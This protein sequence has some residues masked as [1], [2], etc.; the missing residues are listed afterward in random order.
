MIRKTKF[1]STKYLN[2]K[3]PDPS[4]EANTDGRNLSYN[5]KNGGQQT[6]RSG[7]SE[8]LDK[9]TSQA[10]VNNGG[11][12]QNSQA[13]TTNPDQTGEVI[14]IP[15]TRGQITPEMVGR[16]NK[17]DSLTDFKV[18]ISLSMSG[19]IQQETDINLARRAYD[20][21]LSLEYPSSA[22]IVRIFTSST[23]TDTK[24]ERNTWMEKAYPRLKRYCLARGYEFQ[25]VDM[26]WGVRD[27]ATDDHRGTELCLRELELCQTLST[28]PNFI[29]LLSHKYGYTSLPREIDAE[30]F[31]KIFTS[32]EKDDQNLLNKW[33]KRDDNS[34][35]PVFVLQTISKLLPDFMS[36]DQEKKKAAK[37]IWWNE[38]EALQKTLTDVSKKVL[39]EK[40]AMKYIL[41]ITHLEVLKGVLESKDPS[42]ECLWYKRTIKD[43]EHLEPS[44][45][46]SRYIECLGPV[47]KWQNSR[48]LLGKL[49][50]KM[51]DILPTSNV[52]E[53]NVSWAE[54]GIDPTRADHADYLNHINDD[55]EQKMMKMI[56]SA[57]NKRENAG[58]QEP[59][60]Q[61]C[62]QHLEFCQ[63]KSQA[64]GRSDDLQ[65]IK[66][67]LE[68]TS[69]LPFVVHATSG[70]GKTTV[71]AMAASKTKAWLSANVSVVVRFV[72]TTSESTDLFP[73][74]QNLTQ[75]IKKAKGEYAF[76]VEGDLKRLVSEFHASLQGVRPDRPLVIY[77]DALD[78]F[79]AGN[80]ARELFWL[81]KILPDSVKLVVSTL[82][83]AKYECFRKLKS[84][85]EDESN[86]LHVKPF[87]KDD[88]QH[89]I[90]NW[91]ES[92][93]RILTV[94]QR[95]MLSSAFNECPL[96]LYLRL[97]YD[98][99][100]SWASYHFGDEI[101]LEKT[102]RASI[103]ELFRRLEVMHG[104]VLTSR[105][106]GY[107]TAAKSGLSEAELEDILS[108]DDD[109]LNDVYM[110]WTPPIRRLP[111]LL[112]VRL[113]ASLEDKHYLVKRGVDGVIVMFWYHRQ[114]YEA[115]YERYCDP[116]VSLIIHT[117]IADFFSGIWAQGNKKSYTDLQ[118]HLDASD[119]Q[120]VEQPFCIADR[121]NTRK[122]NNLAYHR[123]LSQ[124]LNKAKEDCL[125]N[126]QFIIHRIK[127]TSVRQLMED[128]ELAGDVYPNDESINYIGHALRLSQ[129][130]LI[131]DGDTLVSQMLGRLP[132]N[133]FTRD[134]LNQCEAAGVPYLRSS[135]CVLQQTGGQ[136]QCA[137][138]GDDDEVWFL[139]MTKDGTTIVSSAASN[140]VKLWNVNK[141]KL[142]RSIDDLDKMVRNVHFINGDTS[143][144][145]RTSNTLVCLTLLGDVIFRIPLVQHSLYVI[146]GHE[147]RTLCM[148][149]DE[150][151]QF[152]DLTNGTLKH[153]LT[154]QGVALTDPRGYRDFA[155]SFRLNLNYSTQELMAL[156]DNTSKSFILLEIDSKTTPRVCR[157]FNDDGDEEE[158][159]IDA[160]AITNEN[161]LKTD[162]SEKFQI[163]YDGRYLFFPSKE[164]IVIYNL[165]TQERKAILRH[166][167]DIAVV[168]TVNMTKFVTVCGDN[169]IFIWNTAIE[170]I[171]GQKEGFIGT[172]VSHLLKI[173]NSYYVV[174][175]TSHK[176]DFYIQV[177]DVK[178]G[179]K[180]RQ[181]KLFNDHQNGTG[182]RPKI[183]G[184]VSEKTILMP[185]NSR[186]F[187]NVS[188]ETMKPTLVYKGRTSRY[189]PT[190]P[191]GG[192]ILVFYYKCNDISVI[193]VKNRH[194]RYV[195]NMASELQFLTDSLFSVE[196][197]PDDSYLLLTERKTPKGYKPK[198]KLDY[199]PVIYDVESRTAIDLFD[200]YQ[201]VEN[202]IL[203]G[204]SKISVDEVAI[205]NKNQ[206]VTSHE[207][208]VVRVWD[209]K[210][211]GN[212][213]FVS[214]EAN[215]A[216]VIHWTLENGSVE[217]PQDKD[218]SELFTGRDKKCVLDMNEKIMRNMVTHKL[219][220]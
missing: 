4:N 89:I 206:I 32:T 22:K 176:N 54:K 53:Y 183:S 59:L 137:L 140:I 179:V 87:T 175:L 141:G 136:L 135:R 213:G 172:S 50:Q 28:G 217:P 16:G 184:M 74:L 64:F 190:G 143:I 81:P 103:N 204:K 131:Y 187:K 162:F 120:V 171:K 112:L 73:F 56:G 49:K 51:S 9:S 5:S 109:V 166:A 198:S 119:R 84:F 23:F 7:G 80:A 127:G 170:E 205:L 29:S 39:G 77:I 149:K 25:V 92:D 96:A 182:L 102:V 114:F 168:R 122:L 48:Q 13:A 63:R 82:E 163:S 33:Y 15:V 188:L 174:T 207:D 169:S 69:S 123:I 78:Q 201:D 88:V 142:I 90:T 43:I 147:K 185:T 94:E 62:L 211:D 212:R 61:E 111:P 167:H 209:S 153:R 130:A 173:P 19:K 113:K 21:D 154:I 34:L 128:F 35:P 165:E 139:D 8:A 95:N 161:S 124:D 138:H 219:I 45:Q 41:S 148:Y 150:W 10:D 126:F 108:C 215:P 133:E 116:S 86:F 214:C 181:A 192:L 202:F 134:F 52:Q 106:F 58:T 164:Q 14:T 144:L 146:G 197:S 1:C 30:E 104:Q 200:R 47:E 70:S 203:R 132:S 156:V 79:S 129:S 159:E 115:A 27:E 55:F 72:G 91:L 196:I 76:R 118:G 220:S 195:I 216:R 83:E 105:A 107:I 99:A 117:G 11:T 31:L 57:I 67:Y 191:R 65:K 199:I 210:T 151:L 152:Y 189:S 178:T 177:H 193:D 125:C 18:L 208:G 100:S 186:R 68:G 2:H 160:I 6:T 44:W 24:F 97:S 194:L 60:L 101:R 155:H 20:G 40:E 71:L 98:T 158:L 46:L 37:S 42:T 12:S 3:N 218:P 85:I 180:V 38:S 157:V 75:H 93:R 36:R 17:I 66:A 121:Y 26:R 110:Y 145:V